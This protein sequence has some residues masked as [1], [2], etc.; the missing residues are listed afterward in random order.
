MATRPKAKA[1]TPPAAIGAGSREIFYAGIALAAF[2]I[3]LVLLSQA[4][5]LVVRNLWLDE[6]CTWL[7][8]TDPSLSHMFDA[9]LHGADSNLPALYLI[10]RGIGAIGIPINEITLRLFSS[11]CVVL[12]LTGSYATLRYAFG[13]IPSAA[14]VI[15]LFA[16]YVL[17]GNT[18]DARFYAP[19]FAICT[20]FCYC[21]ASIRLKQKTLAP[22]IA[23]AFLTVLMLSIHY[24]GV[25][26]FISIVFTDLVTDRRPLRQR[27]ISRWPLLMALPMIALIAFFYGPQRRALTVA[28]WVAPPTPDI[29]F[30]F[31]RQTLA[32]LPIAALALLTAI[33]WIIERR[34]PL[35]PK[36]EPRPLLPIAGLAALAGLPFIIVLFSYIVQPATIERYALPGLGGAA[37]L[38]AWLYSR[39]PPWLAITAALGLTLYSGRCFRHQALDQMGRAYEIAT[40][41]EI[42]EKVPAEERILF[43][44]RHDL[45]PMTLYEEK[46]RGRLFMLDFETAEE[47]SGALIPSPNYNIVERDAN[48]AVARSY[49]QIQLF[50]RSKL[51]PGETFVLDASMDTTESNLERLKKRFPGAQI[52]PIARRLFEITLP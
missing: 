46:L 41:A 39:L 42:L 22:Q 3:I 38:I 9:L 51:R 36:T 10:L 5:F 14:A 37:C 40:Y 15:S 4:E 16:G 50:P 2:L 48:R 23:L 12:A 1:P 31:L 8:V 19:W 52:R 34:L 24:F 47:P 49:P 11:S 25:F 13:R 6:I 21:L 30:A 20:W 35:S 28:T 44:I 33:V 29:T 17:T 27:L 43:E 32:L 45:Y 18:F 26:S 7:L